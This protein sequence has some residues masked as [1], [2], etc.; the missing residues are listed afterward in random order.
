[1][2]V[3]INN[4]LDLIKPQYKSCITSEH[5]TQRNNSKPWITSHLLDLIKQKDRY[6]ALLKKY[7]FNDHIRSKLKYYKS[8]AEYNR[9][10]SRNLYFNNIRENL[11]MMTFYQLLT[12]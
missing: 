12:L 5:A 3:C 4:C 11:C 2:I 10:K 8:L 9:K 6:H 1:M 7:P